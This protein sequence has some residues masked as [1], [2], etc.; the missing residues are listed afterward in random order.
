MTVA[1]LKK[2]STAG[3]KPITSDAQLEVYTEALLS[4]DRKKKLNAEEKGMAELLTFLIERY[5]DQHYP[6]GNTTPVQVIADLMAANN[7]KQR[8]LVPIFGHDSI[9][10]EVLHGKR[11]LTIEYIRGLSDRFNVSPAVFF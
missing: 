1:A 5:E 11:P 7:L 10:S 9:V 2:Y 8:D 4:L 6:V 3:L